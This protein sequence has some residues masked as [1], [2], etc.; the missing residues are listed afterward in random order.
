[1]SVGLLMFSRFASGTGRGWHWAQLFVTARDTRLMI[2]Q[3]AAVV[4]D[5]SQ[6]RLHE[7]TS[8][9]RATLNVRLVPPV[10]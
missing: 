10:E 8:K 9:Y 2:A 7:I 5:A 1:M 4:Y 3:D 6:I